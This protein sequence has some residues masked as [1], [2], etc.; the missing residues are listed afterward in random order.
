[1]LGALSPPHVTIDARK[2][3]CLI[4]LGTGVYCDE[5]GALETF[6]AAKAA[7]I[8]CC[9]DLPIAYWRT[10]RRLLEE[11]A[12]RWPQWEPTLVGTRDSVAKCARKD[13]EMKMADLI[14]CPSKFVRDSLSSEVLKTK[15]VV[16]VPFGSPVL[17]KGA[18]PNSAKHPKGHG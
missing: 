17:E 18:D 16:V 2:T 5:D 11:E 3:F 10:A 1:M 13:A 15:T 6:R 8:V 14:V 7:G 12:K 9:Y 4:K